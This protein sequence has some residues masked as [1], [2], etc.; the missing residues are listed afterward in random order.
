MTAREMIGDVIGLVALL[1]IQA[2]AL[3]FVPLIWGG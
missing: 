3:V 1:A 2:G